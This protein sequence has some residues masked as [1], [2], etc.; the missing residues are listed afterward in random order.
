MFLI[1]LCIEWR[2]SEGNKEKEATSEPTTTPS[3]EPM[4][5]EPAVSQASLP[6]TVSGRD[7]EGHVYTEATGMSNEL[8]TIDLVNL[9]GL[10]LV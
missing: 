7:E 1:Y 5:V 6:E 8:S 2:I 10:S 4:Q 9:D 3:T